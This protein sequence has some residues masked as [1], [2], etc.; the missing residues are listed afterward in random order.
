M[1]HKLINHNPDLEKLR[2]E[3]YEVE[4]CNAYL[5]IRN[6]PFVNGNKI[7]DYG[8]L[9]STLTL[10]G[11]TTIRPDNH[12]V[13]WVGDYPCDSTGGQLIKLGGTSI[14]TPI[15][16]NLIAKLNFSQKPSEG[17]AD[18]YEKMTQYIKIIE[19][20]ARAIDPNVTA[21]TFPVISDMEEKSV[22]RYIDTASSRAGINHI[23]EKL[24]IGKIAIIGLGGT[25]SYILD[26]VAKTQVNE[27][28]LFD[29]DGFFQH[30]A[31]R[32]PGAPSLDD[33]Q[34]KMSK[35]EWFEKNYS[36]MR[37]NI[38]PHFGYIDKSNIAELKSMNT[39]FLC[40]DDGESRHMIINYLIKNNIPLIDVGIGLNIVDE[41]LTGLVRITTCTPSFNKH[42][43]TRIPFGN[44]KDNEYSNNIQIVDI[45]ALNAALAVIKWK[46]MLGFYDDSKH[47]HNTTYGI[48]TNNLTSDE[49]SDETKSF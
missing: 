4:I 27:I 5:L 18:Y 22:F 38:I 17:Y 3:G 8:T 32:S 9:V 28:H 7:I 11:E 34:K 36:K 15:C 24:K 2:N 46:K 41:M 45:N 39:V 29:G 35:V 49:R 23:N 44:T 37:K 43:T 6:V 10:S 14:D 20:E 1:S 26:L 12:V 40:I 47:E 16:E 33:L 21:K 19:N 42:M 13:Q 30:N 31:F 48:S 25:G